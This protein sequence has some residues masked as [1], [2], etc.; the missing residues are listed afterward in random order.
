MDASLNARNTAFV[1]AD[2]GP[3]QA[4]LLLL[5]PPRL[6][7][8]FFSLLVVLLLGGCA[9]SEPTVPYPAFIQTAELPDIFMA[10]MPGIRA[11]RLAGDP[12]TRRSSNVMTLPA[13]WSFTTGGLPDKS[14]ELYVLRGEVQLGDL[15]LR[16]GGYAWL[17]SGTTGVPLATTD[18]AQLLYFLDDADADTAIQTPLV[19]N[20]EL[21]PWQSR[22][23]IAGFG[24]AEKV[25]RED[26]GSGARTWL[27]RIEPGA[28][29]PWQSSSVREE[30]L[31]LSG[32][33]WHTE[34]VG[35]VPVTEQYLPGGY[36][37]RPSGAVHGGPESRA[38][39]PS[40]WYLRTIDSAT[41]SAATCDAGA[42][43]GGT[44][45]P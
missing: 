5:L 21:L 35:G 28:A 17:P 44:A 37:Y 14:I 24:I 10:G 38:D 30:G 3:S 25:L 36:Y 27:L 6:L 39:A 22:R 16:P 8:G 2:H 45:S 1:R 15:S 42:N 12:E 29:L 9:S 31:M 19:L 4:Y 41:V 18:G 43:A 7:G 11:K 33:Y 20:E 32:A 40:V 23:D 13:D 34:C 26:P